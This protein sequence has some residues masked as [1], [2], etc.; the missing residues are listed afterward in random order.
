MPFKRLVAKSFLPKSL[1]GK[2]DRVELDKLLSQIRKDDTLVVYKLD[3]L[4][5]SLKHLLE[6]VTQFNEKQIEL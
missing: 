1:R 5:R 2:T 4:G 6:L 3:R